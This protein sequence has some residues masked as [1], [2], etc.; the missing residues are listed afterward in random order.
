MNL[1]KISGSDRASIYIMSPYEDLYA[2]DYK[3]FINWLEEYCPNEYEIDHS[4]LTITAHAE[5][6]LALTFECV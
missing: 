4:Y 6:M 1:K 3:K 2:D 5:V